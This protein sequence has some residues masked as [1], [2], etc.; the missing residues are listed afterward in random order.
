MA[1]SRT[2]PPGG[3]G[4]EADRN[5]LRVLI[6][7]GE[8]FTT[9]GWDAPISAV[10]RKAGVGMGSI[11]RRYPSKEAL[12]QQIC[13]NATERAADEAR[14]ALEEEADAW[15][16]LRHFMRRMAEAR[17]CSLFVLTGR[18]AGDSAVLEKASRHLHEAIAGIIEQARRESVLRPDVT[19]ADV[20]VLLSY[21]RT[22]PV[23][24][25]DAQAEF[26]DRYLE[27]MLAGLRAP[28]AGTG[29]PALPGRPPGWNDLDFA[30][31]RPL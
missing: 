28:A 27:I 31:A 18:G 22:V 24:G 14:S 23:A 13:V 11:Y 21:L 4:A 15:S 10:A 12:L 7:A 29:P 16:A 26:L 8:V 1:E 17:I 19:P 30:P 9:L 6:A 25:Q 3:R 20:C 2:R 5:D